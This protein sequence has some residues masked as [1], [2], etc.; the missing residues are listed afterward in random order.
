VKSNNETTMAYRVQSMSIK[1]EKKMSEENQKKSK[2]VILAFIFSIAALFL[3]I[4][5]RYST[6]NA[7]ITSIN[8]MITDRVVP[9]IKRS[10]NYENTRTIYDL[11]HVSVTLAQIKETSESPEVQTLVDQIQKQIEDLS[12]KLFVNE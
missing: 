12:V 4:Q 2:I 8:R 5:E 3:S 11:K 1:K 6:E 9:Q 7:A 10:G